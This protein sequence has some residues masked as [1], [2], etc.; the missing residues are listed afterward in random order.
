M[1][2]EDNDRLRRLLRSEEE[3]RKD[4]EPASPSDDETASRKRTGNT[5]PILNL[6][7]LDENNMPLP[8]RVEETDL[9]GTRVTN[10]AYRPALET[11]PPHSKQGQTNQ[12]PTYRLPQNQNQPNQQQQQYSQYQYQQ[13]VPK[14]PS[15]MDRLGSFFGRIGAAM[16]GNKGCL[17]RGLILFAFVVVI[18][19]LCGSS[20]LVYQYYTI[21]STCLM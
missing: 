8:N 17:I 9:D 3:T 21:A 6:P 14:G 2:K 12:R 10:A 7:D 18:I 1:N 15:F 19:G 11:K 20:I 4:M 5:T 16:R 13:P